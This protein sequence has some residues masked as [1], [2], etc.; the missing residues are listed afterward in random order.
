MI[1]QLEEVVLGFSDGDHHR[2]VL[3]GVSL[4]VPAGSAIGIVGPSGVGKSTLLGLTAGRL[5]PEGGSISP[6]PAEISISEIPQEVVL[7]PFLSALQNLHLAAQLS[8]T[9]LEATSAARMLDLL[10]IADRSSA[11]PAQLSQGERQRVA[12]ARGLATSSALLL[13]D[14]PTAALDEDNSATVARSLRAVA[15]VHNV[16]VVVATHDPIVA[17]QMHLV[18]RLDAGQLS[19]ERINW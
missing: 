17:S 14:E 18:Y 4:D 7:V 6:R 15:E 11:L 10:G 5:V 2:R 3:D 9:P 8:G 1:V 16:A 19:Q 12:I 13:A